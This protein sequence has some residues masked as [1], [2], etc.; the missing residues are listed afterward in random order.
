MKKN[1]QGKNN[2]NYKNAGWHICLICKTK[3]HSYQ[4]RVYCGRRCYFKSR[5]GK[6]NP[7][8]IRAMNLASRGKAAW[9]NRNPEKIEKQRIKITGRKRPEQSKKMSGENNPMFCG[10]ISLRGYGKG[11]NKSLRKRIKER[12]G[13]ICQLCKSDKALSVHHIN[14]NKQDCQEQNLITLCNRCNG[15][16]NAKRGY[17]IKY[18]NNKQVWA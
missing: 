2:P 15:R 8:A 9:W 5:I 12:D 14:Y 10:W 11:W 16:V 6:P 1:I 3:F 17:W 7:K 4:K 13:F 18:F